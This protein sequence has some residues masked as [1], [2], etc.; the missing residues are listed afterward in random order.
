MIGTQKRVR[1][2]IKLLFDFSDILLQFCHLRRYI[3]IHYVRL[4]IIPQYASVISL[5]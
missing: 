2:N 3:G 5:R 4:E 1:V